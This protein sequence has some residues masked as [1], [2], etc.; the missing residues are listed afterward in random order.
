MKTI[1]CPLCNSEQ[2]R[3]VWYRASY[4]AIGG[5]VVP[6]DRAADV[7]W[8]PLEIS[9]CSDCNHIYQ[10]QPPDAEVLESFYTGVY[11]SSNPSP[12]LGGAVPKGL[13]D[14]F[15]MIQEATGARRG[16]ALEIG[17]YDGYFLH[18]L[19]KDGWWAVGFEPGQVGELGRQAYNL[20]IR[21][22]FY[23]P[24][25]AGQRWDL[26]VSRYVFEHL[27]SPRE[28]LG[29]I[30]S[31]MASG[32][33]LALEVPDMQTRL[34]NGILGCFAHEHISYFVPASFR[35]FVEAAGFEV[36]R[37][38]NSADGL[39]ILAQ[40]P[41]R[42]SPEQPASLSSHTG[43]VGMELVAQ[44]NGRRAQQHATFAQELSRWSGPQNYIMYGGDSHTTDVLVEEW[45]PAANVGL[46]I[47]D[48]PAKQGHVAAGFSIPVMSRKSL[49]EPGEA[50]IILSA[51]RHHD[52]LWDN[53]AEWRERGGA[54]MRFYPECRLV[55]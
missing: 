47:D 34:R 37:L 51:F 45:V 19:Q 55:Q 33:H 49:P 38:V 54:V 24:G 28:M 23:E 39:A 22:E 48:D 13:D 4:P 2:R 18:L 10:S 14:F 15:R 26:V 9:F 53:L 11:A 16:R 3:L 5:K 41:S 52:R 21:S 17:A 32:G 1:P 50:L 35:R 42:P 30:F 43:P 46:I 44:F 12:L 36:K 20:D 29:G 6:V 31:D 40:K 25:K 27:L 7:P 8:L